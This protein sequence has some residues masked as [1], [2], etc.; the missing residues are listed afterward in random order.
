M[1]GAAISTYI[2]QFFSGGVDPSTPHLVLILA[3]VAGG[4]AVGAGI[5]WEAARGGHLWTVPTACVFFGVI[6]EAAATIFLFEFDEGISRHQQSIV[7]AQQS[8]IRSQNNEII[9][10]E[11]RILTKDQYEDIAAIKGELPKIGLVWQVGCIECETFMAQ[12]ILPLFS[13]KT[14]VTI[15]GGVNGAVWPGIKI[16]FPHP[17]L[18]SYEQLYA[19][20]TKAFPVVDRDGIDSAKTF[21]Q[22][23]IPTDRPL[24]FVGENTPTTLVRPYIG[25]SP[26]PP[27]K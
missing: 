25:A 16:F 24:I 3:A 4:L 8:V 17:E 19:V 2:G 1:N 20:F 9:S 14:E 12:L 23:P 13:S 5:I 26:Q 18:A 22:P 6:I 15:Y 10:L 11:P 7:D 27:V 21:V